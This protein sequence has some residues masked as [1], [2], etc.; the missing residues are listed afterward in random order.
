MHPEI[1][2]ESV[3]KVYDDGDHNAFTDLATFRGS[4]YL[5]FRSCPDGHDVFATSRI[6]VMRSDDEGETW[7]QVH[8][9]SVANRD[10]RD[11]H[12]LVFG[13]TLF[14]YT[15]TW[16]VDGKRDVNDHLGYCVWSNDGTAWNGSRILE[17]TYGHYIWR[18]AA[19]GER[20]YLCGRRKR[21]FAQTD[22]RGDASRLTESAMLES[23]DGFIWRLTGFFNLEYGG[24]TAFLFDEQGGVLAVERS[25][26][27][28]P[29]L[30]CRSVPPYR[31]WSR[32]E[33]H[34]TVGGP[35]LARWGERYLV[36]GRIVEEG[37]TAFTAVG[38]LDTTTDTLIEGPKLPSGGDTSYPGFHALSDTTGLLS[39]YSSHEGTGAKEDTSIYLATLST[40]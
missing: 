15:G 37:P 27:E 17:G 31:E 8:T 19:H 14:V 10:V 25:G 5:T 32:T 36:A 2:V 30:V 20:A 39:Y 12:F 11:P 21:E 3:R 35:L 23:D 33:L 29:A 7:S 9:F 34:R 28:R 13:D 26:G 4:L 38:W 16:L 22:D 40:H 6:V 24:E 18:A 1:R